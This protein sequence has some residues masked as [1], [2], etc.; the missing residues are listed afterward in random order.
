MLD[1]SH[2]VD[3][4][5]EATGAFVTD[6]V[7]DGLSVGSMALLALAIGQIREGIVITDI[8]ATIQYVNPA[9]TRITGYTSEEV[10]GK[11][12]RLL[13]SG[14][15][16]PSYYR[17][18][19]EAILSGEVWQGEII[20]RRKDG[21]LYTEEMS[22]TP[23]R[24]PNDTITHFIA[25]KADVTK[26]RAIVAE[27]QKSE[28]KLEQVRQIAPLASWELDVQT[29]DFRVSGGSFHILDW[30]SGVAA[31]PF[32][33]VM[34]V[35]PIPDR[36]GLNN[37]VKNTLQTHEPFDVE[38]RVVRSD[39]AVHAVRSRGQL[40]A[41]LSGSLRLVG[42]T[43]DITDGKL[44][45]EELRQSEERFRSLVANIPDV[46]W[47]SDATGNPIFVSPNCERVYG[48][49][50]EET[51][52]PGFFFS[53][54]HPD[55]RAGVAEAHRAFLNGHGVFNQEFRIQRKDGQWIWVHNKA[56]ANYEKDGR[57]YTDGMISEITDRKRTEE[58]LRENESELKEALLAAQM[59]VW[60][61]TR[62]TD[63]VTWDENL[64][65]IAGRD[66]TLPAPGFQEQ[67]RIFAP[68]SWERLNASVKKALAFG[69]PYE[70]DLELVRTDGSKRWLIARG[71][72]LR[73]ASGQINRLRGTVQDI[74][75]RKR[76]EE[77][78]RQSE[79][80]L[81]ALVRSLDDVVFEFDAEGTYLKIWT[82]DESLLA[83]PGAKLI[84]HTISEVLGEPGAV[85]FLEIFKRVL[86]S[87]RPENC[88]YPL[89]VQGGA[90]WF[91]ARISPICAA[92]GSYKSVCMLTRDIT[93]RKRAEERIR[94]LSLAVEQSPASVVI[95]NLRAEIEYVNPKFT[96]I[97]GYTSEEA[98]GRNP[99]LLKSG[100]QSDATYHELWETL[101][102]GREWRGEFA[103]RKKNGEIYW[104]SVSI[105][106]IKDPG[107]ATTH[108]LAV[109]ED[110]TG[111]K[112]A[113]QD[114]V[115]AEE[116]Y[117]SLV[118]N[119]PDVVWTL[120]SKGDFAF[121]SP[122]IETI[123]GYNINE[124]AQHGA[125]L[126][127]AAIHPDDASSVKTSMERLFSRGDAYDVECRVR[128][129]TGEWIWVH[130]RA[131]ATYERNGVRYADGLL[132]DITERKRAEGALRES[133]ER[134]RIM[135]DG[136]P[137]L[138]WVT[139]A[140]GET[141]F[142]NRAYREF[143]GIS[144]EE[145]EVSKWQLLTHPDDTQQYL[146][147]FQRA[148]R[149]HKTFR[150]ETRIRRAD[151]EWRW[152]D[153][154][155]EPRIS[156]SGEFLGHVG[157][158]AD[159]NDRRQAEQALRSSE[160]K[161]RQLAENIREVF[162]MMPPAA[163]EMLY[164]S[165]AYEQVWGR[166]RDSLYQRPMSWADAIH[167]D[168]L[169]HAHRFF[170][171]QIK[172][173]RIDSEYRIRTPEGQ[174]KWIR[175]RAFPVR[176][177][178]GLLIR[179]VGIAE[180]ITERKRAEEEMRKAK[181]AA[182]AANRAKS[183]FL[184]NMSH[185]V[186]TPMNG[187]IGMAG[188]L[189]DTELT[190]EQQRYA[191]IVRSS[192]EALLA[193]INDILDF[194]KIEAR[195]L[196]LEITDFDLHTVLEYAAEILAIKASEKGLELTCEMEPGT[197][198]LLRGDSGRI[199]QV[200][201]NLLGNSVK[202]TAHGEVAVSVRLEAEDEHTATLCFT[203]RDTGIGFRQQR[204]CNL[205]EPFVQGD[206]SLTRRYGGAG[207]GLAISKQLVE[208]MGG[209]IGVESE[210]GKGSTFWFTAV[211][212]KQPRPSLIVPDVPPSLRGANVLVV[213]DNATNRSLIC[214][215]LTAWGCH[216]EEA[217]DGSSALA[218]LRQRAEGVNPFRLA[219]VDMSLP[220]MDGEELGR[221]IV[222]DPRLK[223]TIMVL[224]TSFGRE[225]DGARLQ[226][227]GFAGYVCKPIVERTLRASL[228]GWNAKGGGRRVSATGI[229]QLS[230]AVRPRG[231]ARI[232]VAEDNLTNQEVA[233][234]ILNTLG[235]C[236][237]V[238]ATGAQA[239]QALRTA[240]YDL[241]LMDCEMPEMDGYTATRCIRD[242]GTGTRNPC[243]PIVALTADAITGDR[244]K[245]LQA[246]MTDY[247]AKP[248]EPQQLSEV[249]ERW[250][251]VPT[252]GG[253]LPPPPDPV[254]AKTNAVFNPDELLARLTG[255]KDVAGNILAAF[256][257]DAP[258]Q[259]RMLKARLDAG[260]TQGA[261]LQAHAF[262]GAAATVSAEAVRALCSEAQEA[263]AAGQ[264]SHALA[265]LPRLEEQFK[266]LKATI[267]Q[268]GWV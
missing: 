247:L 59:G 159:V 261:R 120:D 37:I 199:R 77:A 195:K 80:R 14:C 101:L 36:E 225:S 254:P 92:D 238:V 56:V 228:L 241:V 220:G 103:N 209:Q 52:N 168:D 147:A 183:Q 3:G 167:P 30:P 245:C 252:G 57:L 264:L 141:Q 104:E 46:I 171:R 203:V 244:E 69:T 42:T 162:W 208:M 215:L 131:V 257:R 111:R 239:L 98:I 265:L 34:D 79:A 230:G 232:L 178:R 126:F 169:E 26:H 156:S 32:S 213:D 224:M 152:I 83:R 260:D 31:L 179:I 256:L 97:T 204:A 263:A 71:G 246:G 28:K 146:R 74:T 72:P 109:K 163:N 200:L 116:K 127:L 158:S 129:K 194:S 27:L 155:A 188:L 262:K 251:I 93:E 39:G 1:R 182:E 67:A 6:V 136:C 68:N 16:D 11:N 217:A 137:I 91:L 143:C 237:E 75:E 94:K 22:I 145:V 229:V 157:V 132:S 73:D 226:A 250:L 47:T 197:P 24:D 7:Q 20:N 12:T 58:A 151:G 234:A 140:E 139:G 149:E 128:R 44:A 267:E 248:V 135:A 142:V 118:F 107:G 64:Y 53:R 113:E 51:C 144:F 255:D 258:R 85:G 100:I 124:I 177:E 90:R 172:G 192:G 189:L 221:R 96:H 166:S 170:G 196:R 235:Y 108:F 243:I 249:L 253:E 173:E 165:P 17:D 219:L 18:L 119:I 216:P 117:R 33:Q 222:A 65:R 184:A 45:H 130:D 25:I 233:V 63:T 9:F 66:P 259:L 227:L 87:G 81:D 82:G 60:E 211:F 148:V 164:V 185:E 15:Q 40:V 138:M 61:W 206:G 242:P 10:V 54:I 86:A 5:Q 160:E 210:E 153:S 122:N 212:E 181:E 268:S 223:H 190:P 21:T 187:V 112:R 174:E 2:D 4:A 214:R 38:H 89:E 48:Y 134:F 205:F 202:F 95:T 133:E 266:L 240:D 121:I 13:K 150:A 106:P 236:S 29:N 191:E 114:L 105:V 201:V 8:S 161:F 99:R 84:G 125:N 110:I 102:S 186:R 175:D 193:V 70:L 43:L 50:P 231:Q 198:W 123:S 49:T 35:I 78:T 154:H 76:A 41:D 218:I 180:D 19:W 55:D 23:V 207:L 115:Q 88:E 176:D 62:T